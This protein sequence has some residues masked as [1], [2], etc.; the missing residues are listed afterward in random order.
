MAIKVLPEA[1]ASD[2]ER[3]ARFDREA[4]TLAALNHPHIAAIYGLETPSGIN[5]L[6]MELVE[7]PTL[8]DRITQG[9]I[10]IDEA[11]PIAKQ[12]AE[13]LEAAHE[14]GIIH[15]DL[16]PA[17][18]KIRPDGMVKVLDFGLAKAMEPAG[19][20]MNVSRSP[21]I[22]T[23]AMMTGVG[24]I[25]GT[26]A[27]MS[28]EQARG[29][30]ADK[31]ADIWAFGCV[32]YEMLAGTPAFDGEDVAVVLASV[33][34]GEPHWAA[35]PS[36]TPTPIVMLLRTCLEKE[37]RRRIADMSAVT[38]VLNHAAQLVDRVEVQVAAVEPTP[39]PQSALWRR[40]TAMVA[41]IGTGALLAGAAVWFL[42]R[43]DPP[44]IVRTTI[45][46]SGST[47]ILLHGAERDIAI[48]PD[49][50][51]LVYRGKNQLLVR[52]LNQ[53]EPM[54]L[55]GLGEPRGLF[56]S[57]DGQ[58]VGFFDG[59]RLKKVAITGGAAVTL[60]AV[61]GPTR[62]AAWGE[63]GT[64]VF[65][66]TA[67]ETGLLRVTSGE[68]AVLTKP[69]RERGEGDHIWPEFLPGGKA[70][71]FTINPGTGGSG[72]TQIAVLDLG[73]KT[74]KVVVPEGS[75]AHYVP[76]GHLVYRVR[77]GRSLRAVAFNLGRLEVEG[78]PA[79]VLEGVLTMG[80][81]TA[82][83]AI[84]TNG[85]LTYVPVGV[86]GSGQR[87]VVSVDPQ[88]RASPL[89]GIPPD[90][91]RDV[92]V[93]PDGARIA[94]ATQADV[95]TYD[96]VRATL[97]LLT[98]DT[99]SDRSPLWTPD[100]QRIIFT[101]LRAG[102]PELFSQ[103]ADA[104]GTS[105]RFLARG[106]E[107]LDLRGIGWSADG[108]QLLFTQVSR[109]IACAIGQIAF[110][111]PSDAKLLIESEFCNDFAA[112][113]PD[114]RSIAYD[115]NRSGRY[116]IYV[117]QYPELGNRQTI[118]TG[119]G[120]L[121]LWSRNG[122]EL[123]F[124]SLDGRQMFAVPVQTGATLVAGRPH[125][126]FEFAMPAILNGSR[127]YD[128]APDGRFLLIRSGQAE[129]GSGTASNLIVVQHWFEELKRLVPTK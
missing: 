83:I 67:P 110:E 58:W 82:D 118:S 89:P 17:N 41:A 69:N 22:T 64:I 59:D 127:P 49:G 7:G 88:G 91:Y 13:A 60:S 120:R 51:R 95:W 42:T 121:P 46:T 79:P 16:K 14:Q 45:T 10:P 26:A 124:T 106:E 27:Y 100:G 128:I 93:S 97:S 71:L 56:M 28:P 68:P 50:S 111:R 48:T 35:L 63:D 2:P 25:L 129:A 9:A 77:D 36:E 4:K 37:R 44:S 117:E 103:P 1:V 33:I 119:G 54:V 6:V 92:R 123:F 38:F 20:P 90:F 109:S 76:T 78:T 32:F 122:R 11:L 47:A 113:S 107:M 84:A 43:S 3:L 72:N 29:K 98:T 114:G 23:P 116:E 70:V 53:L 105:E 86:G 65:A 73:T 39:V 96:L 80:S 126:L 30:P 52:S 34:K 62:G 12:I 5:A 40:S 21:T 66:T 18:M 31:R 75:D 24:M 125:M 8:A 15:R 102:Y 61:Q 55:S 104:T 99:A 115:S 101:S 94:L 81:G 74:Y 112:V 108:R 85:S 57:P 19:M 87:T